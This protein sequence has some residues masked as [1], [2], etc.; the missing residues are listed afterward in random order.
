[1]GYRREL[2]PHDPSAAA[3][4]RRAAERLGRAGRTALERGDLAATENL[5]RRALAL[6][7]DDKERRQLIPDLAD[8]LIEGDEHV[9]EVGELAGELERGNTRDHA[10]GA[11]LRVRLSP[12][13]QLDDQLARLDEAEAA[14]AA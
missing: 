1:A 2:D 12:A 10:I 13:G 9:D 7:P 3:L 4:A 6:A 5:L 8:A 11:V 14:L